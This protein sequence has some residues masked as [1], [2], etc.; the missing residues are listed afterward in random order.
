MSDFTP[1]LYAHY[2]RPYLE[3]CPRTGYE[4]AMDLIND[5]TPAQNREFDR[6]LE[7]W[8]TRAF[9]LGVRTGAGLKEAVG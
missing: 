8:A 2:I 9:L 7:F 1:W 5:L 3:Q 4:V 6:A